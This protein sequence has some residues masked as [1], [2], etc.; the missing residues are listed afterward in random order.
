YK[1]YPDNVQ[2]AIAIPEEK[3]TPGEQLLAGQVIRT[4]SATNE[5]ID[6]IISAPDLA[7]KKALS[8]HI[9]EVEKERPAPIPMAMGVTDGDYRFTPDGPGDEPAPG[10]GRGQQA[11]EGSYLFKGPGRYQAPPNYFLIRGDVESHGSLMKPGFVSVATYENPPTEIPPA[12]GMTSGR[13]KA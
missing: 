4:T 10:K 2:R 1:K 7:K 12:N 13:R 8:A 9:A 5:E 11:L 3:R 6:A